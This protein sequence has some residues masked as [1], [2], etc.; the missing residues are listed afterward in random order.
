MT[1]VAEV[2]LPTEDFALG[3]T[4]E[5]HPDLELRVKSV[6]GEG[7]LQA[8]PLVWLSNVDQNSIESALDDDPTVDDFVRLLE[9]PEAE[10]WLYRIEYSDAVSGVCNCVFEHEGTILDAQ[11]SS[12]RWTLRL[13]FPRRDLLSTAVSNIEEMDVAVD[14]RRMVEAGRNADLEATAALTDA[15]EEAITEAYRQGYYDVPREI[16]LEELSDEL[17]ISHQALSERLRRANKVLAGEQMDDAPG[18]PASD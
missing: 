11:V 12:G 1:T 6:V 7:P 9:D 10:E 15:Q 17:D 2:A 8:M 14:I 13:L 5:R 16:S 4:F 18:E 3:A